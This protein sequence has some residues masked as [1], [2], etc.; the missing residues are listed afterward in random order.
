MADRREI[1]RERTSAHGF[2]VGRI[3]FSLTAGSDYED[4]MADI[5]ASMARVTRNVPE[6]VSALIANEMR[7]GDSAWPFL[8]GYSRDSFYGDDRGIINGA[9]YALKLEEQG[10]RKHPPNTASDYVRAV[11]VE[12][13]QQ[14]LEDEL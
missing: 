2:G 3:G 9:P 14:V 13:T 8:S 11:I 6:R 10:T 1:Y 7:A 4:V 5:A 12:R